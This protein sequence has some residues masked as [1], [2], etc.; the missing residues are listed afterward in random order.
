MGNGQ[1]GKFGIE[2][3]G[4]HSISVAQSTHKTSISPI[5]EFINFLKNITFTL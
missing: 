1:C 3:I 4:I 5:I 2:K